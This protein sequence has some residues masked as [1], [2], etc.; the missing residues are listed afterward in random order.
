MR[1]HQIITETTNNLPEFIYHGCDEIDLGLIATDGLVATLKN[2]D[3][4][5]EGDGTSRGRNHYLLYF[6]MEPSDY[7]DV[8]LRVR[9]SHIPT[10]LRWEE[11]ESRAQEEYYFYSKKPFSF[12]PN[13]IE[14]W[15]AENNIWR[16]I[17]E[18]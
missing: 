5:H 15:D 2:R 12:P 7:G 13:I 6:T 11:D 1:I 4:W 16:P 18:I 9:K 3:R 8:V 17:T 14:M 10:R